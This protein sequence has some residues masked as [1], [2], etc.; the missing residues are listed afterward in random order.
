[1]RVLIV[2]V[3]LLTLL[4]LDAVG[5]GWR[6][7]I[8]VDC[9]GGPF[10]YQPPNRLFDWAVVAPPGLT[11]YLPETTGTVPRA[12]LVGS[13]LD[14]F[15]FEFVPAAAIADLLT[16]FAPPFRLVFRD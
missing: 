2:I 3:G 4:P 13:F 15:T 14:P 1:M 11:L 16:F 12:I 9:S 10:L 6:D 8:A 7:K 5:G